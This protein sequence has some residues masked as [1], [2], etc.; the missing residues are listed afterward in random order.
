MFFLGAD[1]FFR[2]YPVAKGRRTRH[3][4]RVQYKVGH[5]AVL[6]RGAVLPRDLIDRAEWSDPVT[7]LP[8]VPMHLRFLSRR[9]SRYAE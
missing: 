8:I 7:S 3:D 1:F 6:T 4:Q 5:S 9:C 2:T